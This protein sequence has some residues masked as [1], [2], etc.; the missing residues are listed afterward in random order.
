MAGADPSQ[1]PVPLWMHAADL[2]RFW[3]AGGGA[4]SVARAALIEPCQES[5]FVP[6]PELREFLAARLAP[7]ASPTHLLVDAYDEVFDDRLRACVARALRWLAQMSRP[8]KGP[9]VVLA[10][11]HAGYDDPFD[12]RADTG[13][14]EGC[15]SA[16]RYFYLGVLDEPQV[17]QLWERWFTPRRLPVPSDRLEPAIAP[18]S[19]LRRFVHVPLIAAFCAWVAERDVVSATRT[20]LY[21]QVV[22][23]FLAQSWKVESRGSEGSLR[24]DVA[25][26]G[27]LKAKLAALA[28]HMATAQGQWRDAVPVE[29]CE[30]VLA[31]VVPATLPGRSHTWEPVRQI[32][33]LVQPGTSQDDALSDARVAWIHRSMHEYLTA[34]RLVDRTPDEVAELIDHRAWLHPPGRTLWTSRS[35]WRPTPAARGPPGTG[36]GAHARDEP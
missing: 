14:A 9:R 1:V 7:T 10:C 3:D 25:W 11:R 28:W 13:D 36:L 24:Q 32:G 20:G 22:R 15:P 21:G 12:R 27:S 35:V 18:N 19:P 33:I 8:Q 6:S 26:Q 2:A 29:E 4:V 17:R 23:R 30:T 16:P 34:R 5:G 31:A